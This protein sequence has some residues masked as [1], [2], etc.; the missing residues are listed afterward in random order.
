MNGFINWFMIYKH[1]PQ[2]IFLTIVFT[3]GLQSYLKIVTTRMKQS[4]LQQHK[5]VSM[6]CEH[7]KYRGFN[8]LR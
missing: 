2:S 5:E 6:L 1:Q 7:V 3:A 8:H 4:T